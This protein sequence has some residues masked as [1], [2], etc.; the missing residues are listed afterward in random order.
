MI[1]LKEN[2]I[3]R[4]D[5]SERIKRWEVWFR[6]PMGLC[7]NSMDAVKA[8]EDLDL[9]ANISVIPVCVAISDTT[10]EVMMV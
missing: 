9:E 10:Y 6:T 7:Q 4:G 5:L 3:V 2:M 1:L 8:L